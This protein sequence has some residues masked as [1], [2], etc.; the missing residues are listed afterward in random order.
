VQ[1]LL[2]RFFATDEDQTG[3]EHVVILSY[4]LWQRRFGSDSYIVGRAITLQGQPFTVAEVM[5]AGF[6]FAP[7]WVTKAELWVPLA[8]GQRA[9]SRGINS[10]R[11][12]ARLK[13]GVS[14]EQAR[15]EMTTITARLEQQFPGTNRNVTVQLLK[16][17]VVGDVRPALLVLLAAASFVLLIACANVAH[18]L[19][20][21]GAARQREIAVRATLGAE[22]WR[23]VCQFLTESLLLALLGGA[24]GLL[25]AFWGIRALIALVQASLPRA[26]SI[27][28]DTSVLLFTGAVS[29]LTGIIFG[30]VPAWQ[31]SGVNLRD[32]LQETGRG[33][34]E[35]LR[36]NRLRS[37][38]VASEFA[39]ACVLMIGAGL[40]VCTLFALHA[41]DPGFEPHHVLS[42]VVSVAGSEEAQ[43][44]KRF[45][46]YQQVLERIAALPDVQSVRRSIT[47]LSRVILGGSPSPS[48]GGRRHAQASH[49][50]PSTE[51]FYLAISEQWRYLSCEDAISATATEWKPLESWSSTS[52][53]RRS[54]GREKTLSESG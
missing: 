26:E 4:G 34:G 18:L 3:K 7:F 11:A 39:L 22:R 1:P 13:P 46:F 31:A 30:V 8:L 41:I 49:R 16:D 28:L 48:K 15:S 33:S 38:L 27:R 9:P 23:I 47:F 50:M 29:I 6:Q 12:F 24:A 19:M 52:A 44:Q 53:W 54:T 37:V 10:L 32:G 36:R 14:V 35:S 51:L 21:R 17:K 25:I 20:A 2:G 5:P 42:A 43:S 45:A 40:M